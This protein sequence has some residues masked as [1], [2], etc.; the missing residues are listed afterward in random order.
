MRLSR[1]PGPIVTDDPLGH[2][3]GHGQGDERAAVD[4]EAVQHVEPNIG[5]VNIEDARAKGTGDSSTN[6]A[7]EGLGGSREVTITAAVAPGAACEVTA[8]VVMECG[9]AL[10][11]KDDQ[12]TSPPSGCVAPL[13][14]IKEGAG[15]R[16]PGG[17]SLHRWPHRLGA[18]PSTTRPREKP[19]DGAGP[20]TTCCAEAG[21]AAVPWSSVS[22]ARSGAD[23]TAPGLQDRPQ[24]GGTQCTL[25]ARN[26]CGDRPEDHQDMEE[27]N[28]GTTRVGGTD[29][30]DGAH[31]AFVARGGPNTRMD[32]PFSSGG[33][34]DSSM[35]VAITTPGSGDGSGGARRVEEDM[36]W[37]RKQ[38]SGPLMATT[39][40]WRVRRT[41]ALK[42][43]LEEDDEVP[44]A[45]DQEDRDMAKDGVIGLSGTDKRRRLGEGHEAGSV[46]DHRPAMT[47][48]CRG[49]APKRVRGQVRHGLELCR[50]FSGF[51]IAAAPRC[52][53]GEDAATR[54]GRPADLE[55]TTA[56]G[57]ITHSVICRDRPRAATADNGVGDRDNSCSAA[58][59]NAMSCLRAGNPQM[60]RMIS[61]TSHRPQG[62][63][64]GELRHQADVGSLLRHRGVHPVRDFSGGGSTCSPDPAK[65]RPPPPP[66]RA[67]GEV[68][69][70]D[71]D[72]PLG[73]PRYSIPLHELDHRAWSHGV[74][75]R[76]DKK[77]NVC[78]L[79]G[80]P[81][82]SSSKGESHGQARDDGNGDAAQAGRPEQGGGS[83]DG[84]ASQP[85]R[86][87]QPREALLRRLRGHT[88]LEART[89]PHQG[90]QRGRGVELDH[91]EGGH[92]RVRE[93]LPGGN[94]GRA[95]VLRDPPHR[96]GE[97][98]SRGREQGDLHGRDAAN[99]SDRRRNVERHWVQP[100]SDVTKVI[101]TE[102]CV[103]PSGAQLRQSSGL[104]RDDLLRRL[105]GQLPGPGPEPRRGGG[106]EAAGRE[107]ELRH[108]HLHRHHSRH[109]AGE[110]GEQLTTHQDP[111]HH[112]AVSPARRTDAGGESNSAGGRGVPRGMHQRQG[113]GRADHSHLRDV[114][115]ER[116]SEVDGRGPD[117]QGRH[118]MDS[119]RNRSAVSARR[120]GDSKIAG[121][122]K[123]A[124][125]RRGCPLAGLRADK[126]GPGLHQRSTRT[127]TVV[128]RR[129]KEFERK[130]MDTA[131]S[132]ATSAKAPKMLAGEPIVEVSCAAKSKDMT[133][134]LAGTATITLEHEVVL[135]AI[136]ESYQRKAGEH[137]AGHFGAA[138][139]PPREG[140][141][142]ALR[143][144]PRDSTRRVV[145]EAQLQN[146]TSY[147]EVAPR[148]RMRKCKKGSAMRQSG[149][150]KGRMARPSSALIAVFGKAE[151]SCRTRIPPNSPTLHRLSFNPLFNSVKIG[152]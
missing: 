27:S 13:E 42:R 49:D 6:G 144:R 25:G 134:E 33:E 141:A 118:I 85:E 102:V 112:A 56:T 97:D 48:G 2:G 129:G 127:V 66:D 94:A 7:I 137:K 86:R 114:L 116:R 73:V 107:A 32:I 46:E 126:G 40:V 101:Q 122:R 12:A 78:D 119:V 123:L 109:R 39:A 24:R 87:L 26:E 96:S 17:T 8:A 36:R 31:A 61:S 35:A 93:H 146:L 71:S 77:A 121:G 41:E 90:S 150:S 20:P 117:D 105:R 63:L 37:M 151:G 18:G 108:H 60:H 10:L 72:A 28:G 115:R 47:Q 92:R 83:R 140:L 84:V 30:S 147:E 62:H 80:S 29:V 19:D 99:V 4:A 44:G 68:A 11:T 54:V 130:H 43:R 1:S 22:V 149:L 50:P 45:N 103:K 104:T 34:G 16:R 5:R 53:Q 113:H 81:L 139:A 67:A 82:V 98:G 142:A 111:H 9:V 100:G 143:L 152:L 88:G 132:L 110:E 74:S 70:L 124:L 95:A 15:L 64:R 38:D 89:V 128:I 3:Y 21:G 135:T 59:A 51:G 55:G 76:S 75:E 52:P 138:P 125:A 57:I 91:R 148:R 145:T 14:G 131:P 136:T 120:E 79:G 133:E 58:V 65:A 23:A 69:C 106:E